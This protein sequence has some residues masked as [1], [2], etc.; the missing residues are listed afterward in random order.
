MGIF[1]AQGVGLEGC[2]SILYENTGYYT[3][4]S[5][6]ASGS[7]KSED[8]EGLRPHL[9]ASVA[10]RLCFARA[11]S[12]GVLCRFLEHYFVRTIE[13]GHRSRRGSLITLQSM[14]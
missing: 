5:A 2:L 10:T 14:W 3:V 12:L 9:P 4:S 11:A 7:R 6:L 1:S 13:C 8:W